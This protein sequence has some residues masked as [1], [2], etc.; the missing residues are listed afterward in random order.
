MHSKG[1]YQWS[2]KAAYWMGDDICKWYIWLEVNIQ[3]IQRTYTAQHQN[4]QLDWKMGRRPT[5]G[6]QAHEKMVNITNHQ[7]NTIQNHN[8]I[9]PHTC[10]NGNCQKD[11]K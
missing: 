5:D 7:G 11:K 2:K 9:A 6:Q 3:N 4:R 8:E 1:N 10:Q